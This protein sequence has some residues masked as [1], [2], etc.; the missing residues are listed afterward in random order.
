M[1][2]SAIL[3]VGNLPAVTNAQYLE[4]LFYA[5][6]EVKNVKMHQEGIHPYAEVT[7]GAVDDGDSAIA[8]LHGNYCA[9]KDLPLVV[10]YHRSSPVVSQYGLKVGKE[11]AA[12]FAENRDPLPIP[13]EAFDEKFERTDVP[14]PPS[15]REIFEGSN[16]S[17][18]NNA[19]HDV[20]GNV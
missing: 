6:G 14:P 7:Y 13:L 15:E 18:Y 1:S 4:R 8:A 2:S 12:A 16:W 17:S 11:Y 10:L 19:S 20:G 5:Y 3:F 9:S